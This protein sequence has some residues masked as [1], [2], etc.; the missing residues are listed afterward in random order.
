M[1]QFKQGRFLLDFYADWC[2][3][4]QVMK[5]VI[6]Q[7]DDEVN[8]VEVQQIDVDRQSEL[9][10]AFNVRNIPMFVYI[11]DGEIVSKGLGTKT[12]LQL[13]EMTNVL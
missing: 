11:E 13:K 9:A 5:P 6:E 4:C 8:E 1:D 3:P 2:G 12:V 10:Q 7:Y